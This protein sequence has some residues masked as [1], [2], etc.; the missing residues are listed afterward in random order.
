MSENNEISLV[1]AVPDDGF[2][3]Y[4]RPHPVRIESSSPS[5]YK[6]KRR[7]NGEYVLMGAYQWSNGCSGGF[8]WREIET[9][10]EVVL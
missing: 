5:G 8:E 9:E 3:Q 1:S 4:M 7:A 6:L 10:I 2:T